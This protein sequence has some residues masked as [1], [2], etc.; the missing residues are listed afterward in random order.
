MIYRQPRI[1]HA[2]R[3]F[4]IVELLV[5]VGIVTI[6][7]GLLIPA[8]QSARE[9][10]R[11]IQCTN[12]LRNIGLG[13]IQH[14]TAHTFYPSDG[15]GFRWVGDPDR[16]FGP[17]QPGGWI[18]NILNYVDQKN[19]RDVGRGKTDAEKRVLFTRRFS[20]AA[21]LFHC[22]SRRDADAYPYT[23]TRYGLVNAER[24]RFAAKTDYA[25]SA[26][27]VELNGGLGPDSAYD[28]RYRWPRLDRMNGISFVRS[29][30]RVADVRDGTSNTILVGEKHVPIGMY[31]TGESIGDDQS[32]LVGDDADIRRYTVVSPVPDLLEANLPGARL[33]H[34]FGSAHPN[35]TR[36]VFCDGSVRKI[37]FETDEAS[38]RKLGR[39]ND[40]LQL[41]NRR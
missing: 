30:V 22:P 28:P 7:I 24:P 41:R 10:A 20:A 40:V 2:R 6:L 8:T 11:G 23:E 37:D 29:R 18:Y 3:A 14:E 38:F 39:R 1:R 5:C 16:G 31:R 12:H 26:G 34:A 36:F 9:A 32:L 17:D 15:W 25:I 27:S 19:L 33:V 21:D 4:T 13:T 35:S